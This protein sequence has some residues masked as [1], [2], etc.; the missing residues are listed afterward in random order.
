MGE[1]PDRSGLLSAH[2]F[3]ECDVLGRL[4][5]PG[6]ISRHAI[7]PEVLKPRGF[8]PEC[9]RLQDG[10]I[11]CRR[12]ITGELDA[13]GLCRV[14]SRIYHRVLK[15]SYSS[16]DGNGSV[17]QRIQLIETARLKA[18]RH[19][20]EIGTGFDAVRQGWIKTN[21]CSHLSRKAFGQIA[22]GILQCP[23]TTA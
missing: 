21:A 9:Q 16:N 1:K 20:I 10:F 2:R 18:R 23:I 4:L 6:K 14:I 13:C 15:A 12:R 5:F 22:K 11:Q 17:A 7:V 19:K 8:L 3:V